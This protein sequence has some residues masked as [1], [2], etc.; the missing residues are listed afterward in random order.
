MGVW[1]AKPKQA[2]MEKVLHEAVRKT[3]RVALAWRMLEEGLAPILSQY[4]A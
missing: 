1:V 4:E 3:P 2:P